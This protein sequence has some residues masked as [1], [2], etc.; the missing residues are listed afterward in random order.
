MIP[1]KANNQ[2]FVLLITLLMITVVVTVTLSIIELTMRQVDLAIDGRDAERAFQAAS[3]GVEC[4]QR[5][6]RV[7]SG[8]I[9]TNS[10]VL[11]DCFGNSASTNSVPIAGNGPGIVVRYREEIDWDN[12]CTEID[13]FMI[14]NATQSNQTSI[15]NF[16][17]IIVNFR[18]TNLVC[19]PGSICHVVAASGYSSTCANKNESGVLKRELLLE[20]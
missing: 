1:T 16:N 11:F 8:D 6:A 5:T 4:A 12:R 19:P 7:E 14:D 9:R 20:F 13:L 3:A 15:D 10:S 2:G 18:S 17:N